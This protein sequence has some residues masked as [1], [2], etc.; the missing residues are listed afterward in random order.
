MLIKFPVME[1]DFIDA[2]TGEL[3]HDYMDYIV[4]YHR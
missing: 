2:A 3:Y 4:K 1:F